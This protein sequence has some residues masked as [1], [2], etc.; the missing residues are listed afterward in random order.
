MSRVT[1]VD[2]FWFRH[3]GLGAAAVAGGVVAFA[4][5]ERGNLAL[6][7]AGGAVFAVFVLLATKPSITAVFAVFG[8]VGG[9]ASF[10]L[11]AR[12]GVSPLL[13]LLSTA[14]YGLM[15]AVI[16]D[17]MVI[18]AAFLYN[19]FTGKLGLEAVAVETED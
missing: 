18:A 13:R 19:F 3:P 10:L 15:Y 17:A 14:A 7:G 4:G 12:P 2:P 11:S 6:A 9:A 1:R 8:L 16:L 5:L